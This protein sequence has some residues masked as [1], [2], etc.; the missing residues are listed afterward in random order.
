MFAALWLLPAVLPGHD[1]A[2]QGWAATATMAALNLAM[3]WRIGHHL[4]LLARATGS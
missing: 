2:L 3:I 4:R 1:A